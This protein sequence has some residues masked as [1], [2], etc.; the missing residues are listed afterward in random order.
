MVHNPYDTEDAK[1]D[2]KKSKLQVQAQQQFITQLQ[3]RIANQSAKIEELQLQIDQSQQTS[4]KKDQELGE[5]SSRVEEE[6]VWFER[7]KKARDEREYELQNTIKEKE[8]EIL[9]LK[10]ASSIAKVQ[11]LETQQLQSPLGTPIGSQINVLIETMMAYYHKPTNDNFLKTLQ[12]VIELSGSDGT[13]EHKILGFLLKADMPKTEEEI[14]QKLLLASQ[15][16]TRAIFRLSQNEK[17]KQVGRGYA[18]ISS[19][20]AEM[21]DISQNWKSLSPGKIFE[22]LMSVIYVEADSQQL[23]TAFTNARDALMEMGVLST[24]IIHEMSQAIE[25]LK[26]HPTDNNEL[27]ELIKKWNT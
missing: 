26:R 19:D 12:Q 16:V 10:E 1:D 25:K 5:Y 22:N 2:P 20:F 8:E 24:S 3:Q 6:R 18:V 7:D 21:A 15:D 13:I 4:D 14:I 9:K 27:V 11:A 17:I 23:I